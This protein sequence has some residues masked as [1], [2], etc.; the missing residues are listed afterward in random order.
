ML[1]DLLVSETDLTLRHPTMRTTISSWRLARHYS[2]VGVEHFKGETES[3]L[4][5]L[6]NAENIA[7]DLG[8]I[9]ARG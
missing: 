1:L 9:A 3:R 7:G 6:V 2:L 5:E 8:H 4:G